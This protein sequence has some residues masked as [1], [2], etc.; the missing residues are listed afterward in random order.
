MHL[1]RIALILP[2]LWLAAVACDNDP[3]GI[4]VRDVTFAP[5]LGID[6]NAMVRTSSGLYY[7]DVEV[8]GAPTAM[9]GRDLAVLYKGWLSDGTLFDE[10]Q[11]PQQ[12]L[13]FRLG[14][15]QVIAGWE[16]GLRGVGVG[17]VRRLVIPPSLAY[18]DRPRGTIPANS[19]LVF[20]VRLLSVD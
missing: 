1:T 3:A 17:G 12:P 7:Q 11:N 10:A 9:P 18:G 8:G 14:A 4:D 16:E 15:G 19:V 2:L 6:L 20:E 5:E 13:R